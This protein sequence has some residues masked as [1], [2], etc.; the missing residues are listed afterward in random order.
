MTWLNNTMDKPYVNE[1]TFA[2]Q[3]DIMFI[4]HPTHMIKTL[5]RTGLSSFEVDTFNFDTSFNNQDIYQPYFSFQPQGV[6]AE[7]NGNQASQNKQLVIKIQVLLI[8]I[9]IPIFL[10]LHLHQLHN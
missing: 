3:G 2:Q 7:I 6:R 8:I 10:Y 5:T 1:L 9:H 4:A